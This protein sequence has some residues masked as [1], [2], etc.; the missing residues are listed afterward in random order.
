MLERMI[1]GRVTAEDVLRPGSRWRDCELWDGVPQIREPSGGWAETTGVRIVAPLETWV[2]A[3]DLGWVFMSS[4]GFLVARDPDRLLA[5][6]GSYVSKARL[7]EVPRR[8]FVP[9]APDFAMEVR[10]PGDAWEATLQKCGIWIAHGVQVV[11]AVEPDAARIAVF[12]SGKPTEIFD[13]KG[14]LDLA[15][16][17][18]GFAVQLEDV[19]R[20]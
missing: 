1:H 18:P 2:R 9:L 16:M 12:R 6:D 13:R 5:A 4:Q 15:P 20:R 10:S 17:L 14:R 3:R 7:L 11:W 8:G 19:F